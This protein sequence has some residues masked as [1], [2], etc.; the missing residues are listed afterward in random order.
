MA[1]TDLPGSMRQIRYAGS[2]GPEVISL[3][4]AP[5]PSP[6]PGQVL[7][8]VVAAGVNRPDVAQR[9]G[10]YPPPP[11]ATE[12]PGLEVAGRVVAL[13]SGV[14]NLT[15][16]DEVCALVIS[17]GYAEYAVAEAA[18][19]LPRPKA[20]AL[21]DA[22]GLPETFFTVYSNVVQRGRLARGESFLVHGGSSGIG[23]TAIQIA[24]HVGARVFA[25]AGSTEKCRFCEDLGADA[26]IDYKQ[27]DFAEEVK[28]LTEGRGVDVILDMIGASYL[29]RNLKSLAPDGRLVMIALMGGYKVDGLNITPIMRNR[30]TF[31]GST[32]RPRAKADKAAIA[33]GLR[34]DIWPE[35]EAGRIRSV[36]HA[37]FPL[38]RAREAHEL[39]ESSAHLGKI[40][41]T[42]GR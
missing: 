34:R 17:G 35:L 3:E 41:L 36:T 25:T 15:E 33:D 42:T 24:K 1:T 6:G 31:T 21:V 12:I 11:G 40:L 37:T 5:V 28:R 14:E 8:E 7:I 16:G 39:M 18:H 30:L 9:S 2:G 23:A 32:L 13:G 20:V 22:G 27:A 26:A 4:T 38:E 29:A 10:V 19:C